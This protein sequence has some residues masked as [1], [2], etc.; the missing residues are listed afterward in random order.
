MKRE[1]LERP[2]DTHLIK[3]RRGHSG[4]TFSYVEGAEYIRRLNEAFDGQWSF[5]IVEHR[6]KPREVVVVGKLT[7][8]GHVKCA[9]GGSSVT[10]SGHTG[11]PMNLAD[12]LKAAATDALKKAA[13]LFGIGLH[14]YSPDSA[15]ADD[16][17]AASSPSGAGPALAGE[18]GK[19]RNAR[20]AGPAARPAGA[21]GNG[22][23][24][25]AAELRSTGETAGRP[26]PRAAAS[27]TVT[28]RQLRAMAAIGRTLGW[29][30]ESLAQRA[31]EAYKVPPSELSRVDASAFIG[32]L[33][34][35]A[36]KSAA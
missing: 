2:F 27:S 31:V 32:E 26:A 19:G 28:E 3:S 18:R 6:V 15:H 12:D 34:Q 10:V 8:E 14:L 11:E 9:F 30:Q 17:R 21:G 4:K 7:A 5:E 35:L 23:S 36:T 20:D 13:S 24:P 16:D 22:S 1:I 33:Q 25:A 29:T